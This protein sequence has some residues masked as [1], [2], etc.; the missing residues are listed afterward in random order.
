MAITITIVEAGRNRLR[1]LCSTTST[2]TDTGSITTTGAA[3]P[4]IK[5]DLDAVQNQGVLTALAKV[6]SQGYGKLA[7]GAQTQAKAR[8]LWLSDDA[9]NVV[10]GNSG[11]IPATAICKLSPITTT[12]LAGWA[13][14]ANVDGPGNPTI[15]VQSI[16]GGTCY[17][18]VLIPGSI[19]V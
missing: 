6:I 18:D 9:A 7:S 8:A 12:S 2:G 17:L 3:S 16:G 14:D 19:G 13:V 15:N 5:T 4:D 10:G 11:G 1:Y